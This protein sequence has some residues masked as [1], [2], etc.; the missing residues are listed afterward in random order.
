M[1]GQGMYLAWRGLGV[2]I[3][4]VKE[5]TEELVLYI[6]VPKDTVA[7]NNTFSTGEKMAGAFLAKRIKKT[8]TAMGVKRLT[9]KY[10]VR[11]EIWT[12]DKRKFA[13]ENARKEMFGSQW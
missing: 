9:V 10:R 11:D 4:N 2:E 13:E 6:S 3:D 12:D 1:M 5:S 7:S 8:M